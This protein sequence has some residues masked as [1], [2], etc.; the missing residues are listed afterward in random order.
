M[1]W[2]SLT[3][4]SIYTYSCHGKGSPGKTITTY[5]NMTTKAR[6]CYDKPAFLPPDNALIIDK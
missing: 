5:T 4:I 1:N 2:N 6:V 3:L